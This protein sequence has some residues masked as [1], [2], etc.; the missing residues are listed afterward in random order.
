MVVE[1]GGG[2][3]SAESVDGGAAS[4]VSIGSARCLIGVC[5]PRLPPRCVGRAQEWGGVQTC[6]FSLW[7]P[8][9][10]WGDVFAV[11]SCVCCRLFVFFLALFLLTVVVV[12]TSSGA[13]LGWEGQGG[14]GETG[15]SGRAGSASNQMGLSCPYGRFPPGL[16]P[17]GGVRAQCKTNASLPR[18]LSVWNNVAPLL[19]HTTEL[20]RAM[21]SR[22]AA[23]PRIAARRHH[24]TPI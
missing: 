22:F 10:T 14:V 15:G 3:A 9:L 4:A 2:G 1:A 5:P 13:R 21:R 17:P 19:P 20:P 8:S 7:G 18:S 6:F 16:S 24:V 23:R 12:N 11:Y